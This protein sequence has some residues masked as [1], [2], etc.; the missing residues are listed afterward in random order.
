MGITMNAPMLDPKVF[1]N[2][3]DYH[4]FWFIT[5]IS[6]ACGPLFGIALFLAQFGN[7]YLILIVSFL[8]GILGIITVWHREFIA[9]PREIEINDQGL[10]L[11]FRYSLKNRIVQWDEIIGS[12]GFSEEGGILSRPSGVG[13]LDLVDKEYGIDFVISRAISGAYLK[14]IGQNLPERRKGEDYK[15]FRKRVL[16]EGRK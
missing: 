14:K 8:I 9:R 4:Y 13:V 3:S 16:I 15:A 10:V 12:Y 5:V 7:S 1:L 2:P 6:I 11:S